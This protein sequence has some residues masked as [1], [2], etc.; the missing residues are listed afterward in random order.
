MSTYADRVKAAIATVGD[1]GAGNITPAAAD[2]GLQN[3]SVFADNTRVTVSIYLASA[4]GDAHDWEVGKGIVIGGVLQR[5]NAAYQVLSSSNGNAKITATTAHMIS[6]D[7]DADFANFYGE[8][9]EASYSDLANGNLWFAPGTT[10]NPGLGI[11]NTGMGR[12][13]FAVLNDGGEHAC[14]GAYAGNSIVNSMR[15]SYFG[16]D[17]GKE[18]D[19]SDNA[20]MGKDAMSTATAASLNSGVG[21]WVLFGLTN[22]SDWAAMGYYAASSATTARRGVAVGSRSA[23]GVNAD[24]TIH[25]GY[26]TKS[27]ASNL[28]T[29]INIGYRGTV[30]KTRQAMIGSEHVDGRINEFFVGSGVDCAAPQPLLFS[31]A[32][33]EGTNVAGSPLTIAAG[34]CTGAGTPANITFQ[35]ARAGATGAIQNALENLMQLTPV[36]GANETVGFIAFNDGV[37]DRFERITIGTVDSAGVGFRQLRVAN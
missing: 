7:I 30:K 25:I 3:L 16:K 15:N 2:P 10:P 9:R 4:N 19:G 14:F 37:S 1:V 22:G 17:C 26:E 29:V 36:Y 13:V 28:P 21:A 24:Y 32:N 18:N 34:R 11:D 8:L 23:S 35:G 5:A 20:I 33:G 6:I 31:T 12:G 27:A